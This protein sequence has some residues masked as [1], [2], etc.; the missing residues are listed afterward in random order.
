MI[1]HRYMRATNVRALIHRSVNA[2][3]V[4]GRTASFLE[5]VGRTPRVTRSQVVQ[6]SFPFRFVRTHDREGNERRRA[7]L[8][9]AR[10]YPRELEARVFGGAFEPPRVIARLDDDPLV[11]SVTDDLFSNRR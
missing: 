5:P 6:T 3:D 7:G 10:T 2:Y 4:P 9:R 11:D 8:G 1:S